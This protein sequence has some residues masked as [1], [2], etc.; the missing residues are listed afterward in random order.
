VWREGE[1]VRVFYASSTDDGVTRLAV[2][3]PDGKAP[4]RLDLEGVQALGMIDGHL[5]Y[6]RGDGALMAVPFDLENVRLSGA[7][8]QLRER[9]NA[10]GPGT[11][12]ILSRSG[13]LVYQVPTDGASR[14]VVSNVMG[15]VTPVGSQVRAFGESRFSPDGQRIAVDIGESGASAHSIWVLARA[16]GQATRVTR[17]GHARLVDWSTDGRDLLFVRNGALW[18]QSVAAGGEPRSLADS[19]MQLVDATLA[20]DGRS[21]VVL[22]PRSILLRLPLGTAASADTIVP[23]YGTTTMRPDGPRVSPDGKWVAFSHR[24]E[25]QVYVRSLVDGGTFQVS[26]E[27]GSDPVWGHDASR[28]YYHTG[29]GVVETTLRTSPTLDVLRRRRLDALPSGANVQDVSSD[30]LALLMQLPI[31]Q[32]AE[33]R[34]AVNWDTEVRRALRGGGVP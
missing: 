34:V 24:N 29:D 31:R 26:D 3:T 25:Y 17:G 16:S 18:M 2:F 8:R 33:V 23:P 13:T 32:G 22:G 6:A 30:G 14:L 9:V 5:I 10:N 12:V 20:P 4:Q 19:G 28:L 11:Q 1:T 7:P 21:V 15:G 27:G